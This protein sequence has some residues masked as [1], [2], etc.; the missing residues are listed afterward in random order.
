[1]PP[2]ENNLT[3]CRVTHPAENNPLKKPQKVAEILNRSSFD[4]IGI[5]RNNIS[6]TALSP[7]VYVHIRINLNGINHE[8]IMEEKKRRVATSADDRYA[9]PTWST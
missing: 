9:A 1:M 2:R 3:P 7:R 5:S 6:E 4:V 8:K